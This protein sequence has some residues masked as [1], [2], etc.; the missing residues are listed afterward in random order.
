[1]LDF[2]DVTREN[3]KEHNPSQPQTPDYPHRVLIIIVSESEKTS[4][5]FNLINQQP[6][7]DQIY[8]YAKD[9]YEPKYQFLINKG[10][11][12]TGLKILNDLK[13][14]LNTRMILM[15]FI[16]TLKNTTQVKDMKY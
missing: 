14:L 3:L 8:L 6:D 9:P 2:D 12:K 15:I 13:L 1:M 10:K 11:L 7:I 4:S 16:K 5:L